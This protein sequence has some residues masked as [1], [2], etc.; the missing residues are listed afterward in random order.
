MSKT[1]C[2]HQDLRY[3]REFLRCEL[4][5]GHNGRHE[6]RDKDDCPHT[7]TDEEARLNLNAWPFKN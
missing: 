2:G 7:W 1:E 6:C 5:L 3:P 4:P